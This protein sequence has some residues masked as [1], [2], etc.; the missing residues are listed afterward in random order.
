[1][2][3]IQKAEQNNGAVSKRRGRTAAVKAVPP[4]VPAQEVVQ[5]DSQAML[6]AL[7]AKTAQ[8]HGGI[9]A[10]YQQALDI[11][12]SATVE[13]TTQMYSEAPVATMDAIAQSLEG[14]DRTAFFRETAR[15]AALS[16]LTNLRPSTEG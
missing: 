16:H 12:Q 15:A 5:S 8:E 7:I 14:V 1:M 11:I 2:S 10:G 9:V 4:V 13:A 3:E 6:Q